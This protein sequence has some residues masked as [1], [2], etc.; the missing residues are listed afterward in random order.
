MNKKLILVAVSVLVIVGINGCK[1]GNTDIVYKR[2]YINEIKSARKHVSSFMIQDNI[3]GANVAVS[4]DGE[5]VYSEGIGWASKDLDVRAKRNTKFRI[6]QLSTLFT[7][8]VYLKLVDEGKINPNT[9]IQYYYPSFPIKEK[10]EITPM[11]LANEISGIRGPEEEEEMELVNTSIEKGLNLFKNDPLEMPPGEYLITTPY[12]HNL[13]GVI[14]EKVSGQKYAD[15]LKDHLTDT[16]H[17]D[18][19]VV[20]NP[21]A[22][23]KG[24]SDFYDSNIIAQVVNSTFCDLR[25]NA[26][27]K[28]LLSNAEDLVKLGNTFLSRDYFS[29]KMQSTLFEPIKLDNGGIS[30]MVNGWRIFKD[31][32]GNM[33]YGLQGS[34]VG[35]SAAL[36]IYPEKNLV[37]GYACNLSSALEESPVFLVADEFMGVLE[38]K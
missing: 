26:P 7:N 12:N 30:R 5:M 11:M 13:L 3:P 17:M 28:G 35:G 27:S 23:I 36:V 15:L 24:R 29:E 32:S 19:T 6:G 14:L 22:T 4:I 2:K 20:D 16:L 33:A 9:S 37:I 31:S 1:K 38:G 34:V 25:V 8:A 18:N 10:G 21:F